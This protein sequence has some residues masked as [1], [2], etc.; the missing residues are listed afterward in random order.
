MNG[1]VKNIKGKRDKIVARKQRPKS[2]GKKGNIRA[3]GER[4]LRAFWPCHITFYNIPALA[5]L[6]Y[7][8]RKFLH[9]LNQNNFITYGKKGRLRTTNILNFHSTLLMGI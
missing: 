6:G 7:I 5:H 9:H 4:G 2:V 1:Q 8:G 3:R